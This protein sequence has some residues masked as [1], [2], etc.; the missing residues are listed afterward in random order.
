MSVVHFEI[1]YCLKTEV[2][3]Q[4]PH[5]LVPKMAQVDTVQSPVARIWNGLAKR[6]NITKS[7]KKWTLK[8]FANFGLDL[9]FL[10]QEK[11]R[12]GGVLSWNSFVRREEGK[13]FGFRIILSNRVQGRKG[14]GLRKIGLSKKEKRRE[15]K[16]KSE[17]E[18]G[19]PSV[20]QEEKL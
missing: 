14:V 19:V 20:K 16:S 4:N 2:R 10:V 3:P 1:H 9:G 13:R 11:Q 18:Q 15:E 17:E 6:R 8:S 12:E 7:E 5:T